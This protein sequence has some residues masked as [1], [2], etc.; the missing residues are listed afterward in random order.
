MNRVPFQVRLWWLMAV[1]VLCALDSLAMRGPLSGRGLTAITL[2]LGGLPMANALIFVLLI[3]LQS[4]PSRMEQS[5]GLV[6]CS[7]FGTVALLVYCL[8]SFRQPDVILVLLDRFLN[9]IGLSHT[10]FARPAV[11]GV[12]LLPQLAVGI[13]GGWLCRR[14]GPLP[15]IVRWFNEADGV[16]YDPR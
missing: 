11:I 1:V 16:A 2:L 3:L 15:G 5:P 7:I 13:L 12:L 6:G 14:F 10:L 8:L 9:N 4:S